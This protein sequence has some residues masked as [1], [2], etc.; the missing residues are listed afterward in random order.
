MS[1]I[2]VIHLVADSYPYRPGTSIRTGNPCSNGN[3][4]PSIEIASIA[5]RPSVASTRGVPA[6]N[7]STE[8]LAICVAPVDAP[9]AVAP[10]DTTRP[11]TA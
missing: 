10:V 4:C 6:V 8:R 2:D 1:S 9:A 7:P 3:A 11:A 5:S